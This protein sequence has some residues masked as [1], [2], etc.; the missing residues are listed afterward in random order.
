[1]IANGEPVVG[2]FCITGYP[3]AVEV[4]GY[5]GFDFVV[6]D[7]EHTSLSPYGFELESCI[8]AAYTADIFPLVRVAENNE[9]MILKALNFGAKGIIAP[10]VNTKEDAERL[11]AAAHY[12]P[13]GRRSSAPMVPAARYGW[14]PWREYWRRSNAETLVIPLLEEKRAMGKLEEI[15]AVPGLDLVYFG[16]F[17]LS[18]TLG[19]DG[20]SDFPV[21]WGY[22]D[23]V[24]RVCRKRGLPVMNLA[25]NIE[26]AKKSLEKG[27]GLVALGTDLT[28]F[29]TAIQQLANDVRERIRPMSLKH[30]T[31]PHRPVRAPKRT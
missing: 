25:W 16:P 2:H 31:P 1:M 11:V 10:H 23:R 5:A 24:I 22:L 15:V 27:C 14:T 7:E 26:S 9:K 28:L 13:E 21:I 8:R 19:R 17:D 30:P 18:M 12:A 4:I 29:N 20:D 6:I 3:S